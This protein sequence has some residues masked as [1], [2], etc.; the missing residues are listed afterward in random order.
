MFEYFSE[1]TLLPVSMMI[2]ASTYKFLIGKLYFFVMLD[3]VGA[4]LVLDTLFILAYLPIHLETSSGSPPLELSYLRTLVIVMAKL[5]QLFKIGSSDALNYRILI[6]LTA[7][8]ET[9]RD[10]F[11]L[12]LFY[13]IHMNL[14]ML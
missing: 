5:K 7:L 9:W 8:A 1:S 13:F 4:L 2:F 10:L 12:Q 3:L 11:L 14:S 6:S